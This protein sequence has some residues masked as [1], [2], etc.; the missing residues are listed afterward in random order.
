MGH[1][2]TV[3]HRIA[4]NLLH[5]L[6]VFPGQAAS[7]SVLTPQKP[8]EVVSARQAM[9]QPGPDSQAVYFPLGKDQQPFC[10]GL[11]LMPQGNS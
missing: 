6:R 2:S 8:P 5:L 1:K 4:F 10:Q 9:Q 11:V 3:Q 7:Q